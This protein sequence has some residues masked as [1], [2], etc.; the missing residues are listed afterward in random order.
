[1]TDT[2]EQLR[3][4]LIRAR[5]YVREGVFYA[6]TKEEQEILFV[7]S[8]DLLEK[9]ESVSQSSLVIGMIGGTGVGKSSLM[10]ALAGSSIAST[11]HRRPHTDALLLYRFRDTP[12]P[13]N[14]PVNRFP[15]K[16]VTHDG[17][18]IR[19]ILICDL[20]DFDS[21]SE[22]HREQ[23]L[24]FLEYLDLV[25][26]V[27]S[28]EKYADASFFELLEEVS[29]ARRNFYFVVN[30]VD[31]LFDGVNGG[32]GYE[33]LYSL[34]ASLRQY[35][36]EKHIQNPLIYHVS[37]R[38]FM[39]DVTHEPWNHLTSLRAELF[40][41]RELKEVTVI[42]AANID[43]EADDLFRLFEKEALSLALFNDQINRTAEDLRSERAKW[44]VSFHEAITLWLES[45]P[46]RLKLV[47]MTKVR[48]ALVG[49]SAFI[50]SI[51]GSMA[52]T[53]T[54]S[55]EEEGGIVSDLDD[56]VALCRNHAERIITGIERR[57]LRG[58]TVTP[59]IERLRN[60]FDH[61]LME[62]ANDRI[63]KSGVMMFSRGNQRR[64]TFYRGTQ[65]VVY[66]AIASLLVFSLAGEEAWRALYN[67][68]GVAGVLNCIVSAVTGAFTPRGLAA[69]GSF[70][71]INVVVGYRF[72]SRYLKIAE[73]SA[74]RLLRA[75]T[76]DLEMIWKEQ[77][78]YLHGVLME[79][80][81]ELNSNL[82]ALRRLKQ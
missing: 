22:E 44:E 69:L 30:K 15:W 78:E 58:G 48:D 62:M 81:E 14:F 34:L 46:L 53:R 23:V 49:P 33:K 72:H 36:K 11:S 5:A 24:A 45:T 3:E 43:R 42:K 35:L 4:R 56:V 28:P 16:E 65:Y 25:I 54:D 61:R 66:V 1:M 60:E 73:K 6:L 82:D 75:F 26:W 67:N 2:T 21:I 31:I 41:Q 47:S 71:L 8:G 77:L 70:A 52:S 7:K 13:S 9:L 12:L 18:S 50:S 32:S 80:G 79:V 19:Q 39:K 20:P 17:A 76:N 59:L 38:E 40:R 63:M 68:P 10:N 27:T 51:A 55:S 37:A 57:L 64:H 74:D 29:K